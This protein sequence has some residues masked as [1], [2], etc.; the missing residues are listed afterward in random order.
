MVCK[1]KRIK[2][3]EGMGVRGVRGVRGGEGRREDTL[4]TE[5]SERKDGGGRKEEV[6]GEERG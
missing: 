4:R 5:R 3:G 2:R 6:G 1:G